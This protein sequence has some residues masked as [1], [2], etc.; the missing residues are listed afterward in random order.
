MTYFPHPLQSGDDGLLAIGG[1]LSQERL[2]LAYRYGIFPWYNEP[3]I[4][5]WYIHPRCVLFPDKVKISKSMRS[6]INKNQFRVTID[7]NFEKVMRSCAATKRKDQDSTWIHEDMIKAYCRLHAQGYAHSLEVWQNNKLIGGL[8][9]IAL[10]KMFFGE[11]MFSKV[12]NASK[13]GLIR[14]SVFLIKKGYNLID[15]QQETDH[16]KS[17]GAQ[18]MSKEE[19]YAKLKKN[20]SHSDEVGKWNWNKC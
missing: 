19:F 10:G 7:E 16:M 20:M 15:C 1:E 17:L 3:P 6:L 9:G 4:L 8:Y 13:F 18:L 5:W 2:L 14:L 11:S 12:S